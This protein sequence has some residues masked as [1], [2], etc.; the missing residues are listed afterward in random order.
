MPTLPLSST[1]MSNEIFD[2]L[3]GVLAVA[4]DDAPSGDVLSSLQALH[5]ARPD[6]PELSI[7]LAQRHLV[8]GDFAPAREVLEAID[9]RVPRLPLVGALLAFTLQRMKDPAWRVRAFEVESAPHDDVSASLLA[10]LQESP[11]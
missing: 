6:M 1:M 2:A 3:V 8:A 10:T 9:R 11:A 5:L 4:S 7:A